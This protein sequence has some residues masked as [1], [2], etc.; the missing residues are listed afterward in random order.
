MH[1]SALAS[2]HTVQVERAFKWRVARTFN[3][4][5]LLKVRAAHTPSAASGFACLDVK[6]STAR[7]PRGVSGEPAVS[8]S[9]CLACPLSDTVQLPQRR[10]D[11]STVQVTA[12]PAHL[13]R[14]CALAWGG[15]RQRPIMRCCCTLAGWQSMRL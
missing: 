14:V 6:H 4:N 11:A 2:S 1:E 5:A 12:R 10:Q 3:S 7:L 15:H 13:R 8:G 9:V